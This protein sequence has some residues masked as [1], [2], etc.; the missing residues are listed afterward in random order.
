MLESCQ[1]IGFDWRCLYLNNT[2]AKYS[3]RAREEL[4]G[5]TLMEA[6]PGIETTEVFA[7]LRL[8]MEKRTAHQIRVESTFPGGA[9]ATYDCHIKPVG[10]GLLLLT[11]RVSDSGQTQRRRSLKAR[12]K[13][14][15]E[16]LPQ[17]IFETDRRGTIT[18]ANQSALRW[19][20]YSEN[21]FATG[22]SIFQLLVPQDRAQ[23]R[24]CF[25][26]LMNGEEL[27]PRD[28]TARKKDGSTFPIWSY[29]CAIMRRNKPVGVRGVITNITKRKN[30]ESALRET[31]V[32]YRD[33]FNHARDAIMILDLK[34][35]IVEGNQALSVLTGYQRDE[36]DGMNI[37]DMLS[38]RAF[39]IAMEK[40]KQQLADDDGSYRYE[41]EL[42]RKDGTTA[43]GEFVTRLISQDGRPTGMQAI[44]RDVTEQ[45]R[46]SRNMQLYIREITKAQENERRRIAREL[47][48]ELA[49]SLSSLCLETDAVS[50]LRDRLPNEAVTRLGKIRSGLDSILGSVRCFSHRLRPGDLDVVGL[51][52]T[53]KRLVEELNRE[54]KTVAS[55]EVLG[56]DKRLPAEVELA[57]FRIA[58]EALRNIRKHSDA[59]EVHVT[60]RFSLAK[61]KL[62]ITDNGIGFDSPRLLGDFAAKGKLGLI[63]MNE[64]ARLLNGSFRVNSKYGRG[65]AVTVEIPLRP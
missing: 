39:R 61:V 57:L 16:S 41:L 6:Y 22:L 42:L 63:G 4:V 24:D 56:H 60:V 2:A 48:D 5:R 35:N 1:I 29:N 55:L 53:L 9:D 44:V 36:L 8:A 34:G 49:Q 62:D 64:R 38:A 7:K 3:G 19:F 46:L 52:P 59:T 27:P 65:T 40:Q 18:Y 43:I 28:Y 54:M 12:Y 32:R 33:I 58:Q 23:A 20:G 47:H 14:L 25:R 50:D 17:A 10:S 37:S 45:K 13:D 21:D 26:R 15:V 31:E 11:M 51:V 30:V